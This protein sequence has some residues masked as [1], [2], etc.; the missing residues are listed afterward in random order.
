LIEILE[1]LHLKVLIIEDNISNAN[2]T[3]TSEGGPYIRKYLSITIENG[4]ELMNDIDNSERLVY[5]PSHP[6]AIRTGNK[7][8][9]VRFPNIDIIAE[10][11]DLSETILLYNSIV[12][13][14]EKNY[15]NIIVEKMAV[16][17]IDEIEH[18]LRIEKM[19]KLILEH[20]YLQDSK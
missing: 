6:D 8:G 4:V 15:K 17:P 14:I 9:Y 2:T 18:G 3:R 10:Y 16:K 5:D 12:G 7:E 20:I 11:M 19:M 13:F 1:I